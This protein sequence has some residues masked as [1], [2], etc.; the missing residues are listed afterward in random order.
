MKYN[1]IKHKEDSLTI[2]ISDYNLEDKSKW[3]KEIYNS[4]AKRILG[5]SIYLFTLQPTKNSLG[6]DY[7]NPKKLWLSKKPYLM[8]F[9]PNVQEKEW[10]DIFES[11]EFE[12]GLLR[13]VITD[14]KDILNHTDLMFSQKINDFPFQLLFFEDDGDSFN[15]FNLRDLEHELITG[16]ITFDEY[17]KK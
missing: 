4:L 5:K 7:D 17:W 12:R 13:V 6:F 16:N 9:I 3:T 11:R 14:S 10:L 8:N 2:C 15:F 1:S